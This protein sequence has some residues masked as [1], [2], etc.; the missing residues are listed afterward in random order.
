[1]E[2][3]RAGRQGPGRA[4]LLGANGFVGRTIAAGLLD[5]GWRVTAVV[6]GAAGPDPRCTTVRLDAAEEPPEAIAAVIAGAELVV[7]AAG[8]LWGATGA[9]LDRGNVV[10]VERLVAA[11]AAA[12]GPVRLV[13]LGS[14]FEYGEQPPGPP[15]TE[16]LTERPVSHYARTKLAATRAITGAVAAGRIDA[17]VLRIS[18][19]IGAWAPVQ[20][21]LGGLARQLARDGAAVEVP[22]LSGRRDFVDVRDVSDAVLCAATAP[23]VPPVVNIGGGQAVAV[24]KVVDLLIARAGGGGRVVRRPGAAE[25]RDAGVSARPMDIA[26]AR[27]ALGWAPA[28]S[29]AEAID[30]LWR[31]TRPE[32][33]GGNAPTPSFAANGDTADG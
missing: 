16:D 2:T 11:L 9:E 30:A 6:R 8:A 5:A 21:L 24:T 3:S 31:H 26:L 32:D 12:A 17:V 29:P 23:G 7:N 10:L 14:V 33:I 18:T 19:V 20:S 22:P 28:R 13:H 1:M 4:V 15:L 25:R 27:R